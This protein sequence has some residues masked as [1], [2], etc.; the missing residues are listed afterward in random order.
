MKL[1]KILSILLLI[2]SCQTTPED[3]KTETTPI[4]LAEVKTEK[5]IP[6]FQFDSSVV[7]TDNKYY[8]LAFQGINQM[9]LR[10]NEIVIFS[11]AII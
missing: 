8:N 1:I 7:H 11:F 4:Q 2:F 3:K 6:K 5:Q 9:L 10:Y